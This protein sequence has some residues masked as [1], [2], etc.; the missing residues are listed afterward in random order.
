MA[1]KSHM[2]IR[3]IGSLGWVETLSIRSL[4][5]VRK[6]AEQHHSSNIIKPTNYQ[7]LHP[8]FCASIINIQTKTTSN[9]AEAQLHPLLGEPATNIVPAQRE[10]VSS[11]LAGEPE[12]PG[13]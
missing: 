5:P 11:G 3:M 10:R 1:F 8:L 7:M 4:Y 12:K 13:T 9:S 6:L 2:G